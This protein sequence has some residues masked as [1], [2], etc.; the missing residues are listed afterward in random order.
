MIKVLINVGASFELLKEDKTSCFDEDIFQD[1]AN[2]KF[3]EKYN[4]IRPLYDQSDN[5]KVNRNDIEF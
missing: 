5:I 4:L 2:K 3:F 1:K